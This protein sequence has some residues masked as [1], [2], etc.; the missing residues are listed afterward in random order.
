MNTD[1]R[2]L[3]VIN[4][5]T[6]KCRKGK[7]EFLSSFPTFSCLMTQLVFAIIGFQTSQTKCVQTSGAGWNQREKE[8]FGNSV[9]HR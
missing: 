9:H 6:G 3:F 5:Q 4:H 8:C 2:T 1:V 7:S